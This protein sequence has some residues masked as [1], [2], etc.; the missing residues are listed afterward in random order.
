MGRLSDSAFRRCIE[1]FLLA[2]EQEARDGSLPPQRDIAWEL[3]IPDE[4][5]ASDLHELTQAGI[6]TSTGGSPFIVKFQERQQA[7]SGAERVAQ[8]RKR[9]KPV[10]QE[11]ITGNGHVTKSYT[12]IDIDIE[13]DIYV[14]P[15]PEP[16]AAL[17]SAINKATKTRLWEK[18]ASEFE[19]IAFMVAGYDCT[20]ADIEAF[21]KWWALPGNGYYAGLPALKS[22]GDEFPNFLAQRQAKQNGHAP[23]PDDGLTAL[24]AKMELTN[25]D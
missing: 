16:I 23:I 21:S 20:S 4:Q 15:L 8:F 3:R 7:V 11:V 24:M 25:A 5:L 6:V 17:V 1:L 14:H 10:T 2:G 22:F 12:D 18:T 19:S 9:N 13:K